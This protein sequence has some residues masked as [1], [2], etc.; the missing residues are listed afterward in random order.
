MG[1]IFTRSFVVMGQL[2]RVVVQTPP[3]EQ[4]SPFEYI[5]QS[6]TILGRLS[7][8]TRRAFNTYDKQMR[9]EFLSQRQIIES[10]LSEVDEAE[11][12]FAELGSVSEDHG[13]RLDKQNSEIQDVKVQ[14][15]NFKAI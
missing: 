3:S 9:Q 8:A 6:L 10:H 15:E 13:H 12:W 1:S 11:N 14:L 4:D 5:D 7:D 2:A